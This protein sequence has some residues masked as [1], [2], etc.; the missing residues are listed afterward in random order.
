M[1]IDK[2]Q[3]EAGRSLGL[4]YAQT[5]IYIILPQAFKNVLP[6]LGNEFIVLVK[7]TSIAGYIA[8]TDITK[9]AQYVGS[10]TYDL[11]TPLLIAAAF[12]LILVFIL[13]KLQ[14]LLERRL[15]KSDRR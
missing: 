6:S 14:K 1:S 15:G 11:I 8:V 7:E 2:G 12:Y 10:K 4:G 5:M 13:T 9:A 3:F